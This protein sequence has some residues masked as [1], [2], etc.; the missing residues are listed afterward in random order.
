M[1]KPID[2]FQTILGTVFLSIS[3]NNIEIEKKENSFL[4]HTKAHKIE[5]FAFQEIKDWMDL[6]DF[7]IIDSKGWIFR[8]WKINSLDEKLDFKC[9]IEK[10]TEGIYS[11]PDCGQ[12]LDSYCDNI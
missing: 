11:G 1:M 4:I 5:I 2:S 10:D 7:K 3:E 12:H 9:L 8:I 6:T